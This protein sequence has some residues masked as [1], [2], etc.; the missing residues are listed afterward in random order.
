[1]I[2]AL[3]VLL[4]NLIVTGICFTALWLISIALK[5]PSYVDSW[6]ALGVVV[7]AW[8]TFVQLIDPGPHAV[9]LLH[10]VVAAGD[11]A[12]GG[13]SATPPPHTALQEECGEA[14][15]SPAPASAADPEQDDV[16]D[17]RALVGV[18]MRRTHHLT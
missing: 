2:E 9:A 12:A 5:D 15:P 18:P 3:P 17:F 6:W 4:T 11:L 1:M 16:A 8:S 14:C 7:L 10:D 13:T